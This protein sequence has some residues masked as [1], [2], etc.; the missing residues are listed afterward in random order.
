MHA[1]LRIARPVSSVEQSLTM[2]SKG[3]GL[4]EIGRFENHQGFDGVMLGN[5]GMHYHFEFTYCRTHPV[6]PV[7]TQEDLLVLYL[8]EQDEWRKVCSR[9]LE[10]GFVEVKSF[11]PYWQLRGRTFED[12]DGYRVVLQQASWSNGEN[13]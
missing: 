12:P 8:P 11:N 2:Y 13:P 6:K 5:S 1:H 9:M 3:L 10:A 4:A 7:P